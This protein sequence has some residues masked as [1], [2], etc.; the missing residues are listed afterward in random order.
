MLNLQ[1]YEKLAISQSSQHK[2][3][4]SERLYVDYVISVQ[5]D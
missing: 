5:V 3:K 1:F 4:V 2:M